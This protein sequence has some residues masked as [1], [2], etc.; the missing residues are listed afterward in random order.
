[1]GLKKLKLKFSYRSDIDNIHKDFYEKCIGESIKYDRATGYF[2][3]GSLVLMAKGLESFIFKNG[4]I[5][6]DL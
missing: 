6:N 1:M 5:R 2:T 3:S 4:K